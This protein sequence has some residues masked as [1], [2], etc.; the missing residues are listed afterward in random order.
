MD[1]VNENTN[2]YGVNSNMVG[3]YD[4]TLKTD[5]KQCKK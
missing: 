1:Y 5:H 2:E 4:L 3:T